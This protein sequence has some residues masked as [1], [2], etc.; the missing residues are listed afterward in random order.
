MYTG[1]RIVLAADLFRNGVTHG[2]ARIVLE[3]MFVLSKTA[4]VGMILAQGPT[5]FKRVTLIS[6]TRNERVPGWQ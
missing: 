2:S 5:M 3:R 1:D 4:G 6:E